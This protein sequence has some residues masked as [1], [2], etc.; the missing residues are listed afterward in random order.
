MPLFSPNAIRIGA[1]LAVLAALAACAPRAV[2]PPPPAPFPPAVPR[3]DA[4]LAQ[5]EQR[6]ID[7]RMVTERAAIGGCYIV[8][9][10][11][12]S[13][14]LV[15][16]DK[17]ADMTCEMAL[18]LDDF[19]INVVQVAAQRYFKRRVTLLRHFGAYSCRNIAG[20]RRLSEHA[21]GQA[22]DIAGF[23]LDGG[24]RILVKDD[25]SGHG[26][27]S[28]FLQEVARGACRIFNVVLTP[29]SNAEHLDHLHLDIGPYPLCE[30]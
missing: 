21:H 19:E 6:G 1:V 5:L 29:K 15:P 22:I 24:E 18:M 20:T 28:R 14:L 13:A 3:G 26:A 12:L 11:R 25:W 2:V 4:C 16:F 30:A 17:P 23:E 8:N 7:Y 9:A 27:R 10:V